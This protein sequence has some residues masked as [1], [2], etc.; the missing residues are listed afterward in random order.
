MLVLG[1]CG[2]EIHQ[3]AEEWAKLTCEGEKQLKSA[4]SILGDQE[5]QESIVQEGRRLLNE[6]EKLGGTL[7]RKYQ[8]SGSELQTLQSV[9]EEALEKCRE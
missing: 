2:N 6:A 5:K 1:A 4:A 7:K 9:Y 8:S 3:D